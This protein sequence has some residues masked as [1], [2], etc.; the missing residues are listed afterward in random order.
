[1]T[2]GARPA[3]CHR[4]SARRVNLSLTPLSA[5]SGP[6]NKPV[7]LPCTGFVVFARR[8]SCARAAHNNCGALRPTRPGCWACSSATGG[9]AP[10]AFMCAQTSCREIRPATSMGVGVILS[11]ARMDSAT[12]LASMAA[13]GGHGPRALAAQFVGGTL[14]AGRCLLSRA[15]MLRTALCRD[16]LV[17]S[18]CPLENLAH[19]F[20]A[21]SRTYARAGRRLALE[22]HGPWRV[23]CAR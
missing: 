4:S 9:A 15:R 6:P 19:R 7:Q 20:C 14:R 13:R 10:G 22:R 8:A 21:Q 18:L 5:A 1:M 12:G 23:P 17:R 11:S 2:S 3:R 16:S